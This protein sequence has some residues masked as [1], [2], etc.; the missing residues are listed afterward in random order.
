MFSASLRPA[1]QKAG[2]WAS[3]PVVGLVLSVAFWGMVGFYRFVLQYDDFRADVVDY[4][5]QSFRPYGGAFHVFHVP[6]YPWLLRGAR[7]LFDGH[8]APVAQMRWV[9]WAAYLLAAWAVYHGVRV[10]GGR[11]S[12]AAVA[13]LFYGF[14]PFTG[15]VFAVSPWAD[16]PATA[17]FFLAWS[18]WGRGHLFRSALAGAYALLTHKALWPFT[19]LWWL[20]TVL[21]DQRHPA[22]RRGLATAFLVAPLGVLWALGVL[23]H[24]R[25]NWMWHHNLAMEVQARAGLP[26]FDG[27]FGPWWYGDWADRIKALAL[28]GLFV[29]VLAL[30][31]R[32]WRKRDRETLAVTAAY[33]GL[34]ALVNA[35]ENM[36]L[37]RY[38]R[39]LAPFVLLHWPRLGF[40]RAWAGIL[41]GMS[42]LSNLLFVIYVVYFYL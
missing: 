7:L 4:W 38:G 9:T 16:V 23:Y 29:L 30:G 22:F 12:Q 33:L 36:V 20:A 8:L 31:Y 28:W 27:L 15:L 19:L 10:R 13:A 11:A 3:F 40:L 34:F 6:G 35:Y 37:L 24:D 41:L 39:L 26:L 18:M 42:L 21:P 1:F 14:W 5:E 32:A 17:F 25:W 2:G